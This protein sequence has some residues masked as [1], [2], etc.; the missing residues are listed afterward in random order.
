MAM[1]RGGGKRGHHRSRL[2]RGARKREE[3]KGHA[4]TGTG[5]LRPQVVRGGGG[6]GPRRGRQLTG[7]LVL[8]PPR[9][10]RLAVLR[11]RDRPARSPLAFPS[12]HR[13]SLSPRPATGPS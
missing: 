8:T 10:L 7:I 6:I 4:R 2:C 9:A 12:R 5:G 3:E 11:A 13:R 1:A